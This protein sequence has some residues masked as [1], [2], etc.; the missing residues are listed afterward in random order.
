MGFIIFIINNSDSLIHF[1]VLY[2]LM[3]R[4][5]CVQCHFD[6]S[7]NNV[8]PRKLVWRTEVKIPCPC[9]KSEHRQQSSVCESLAEIVLSIVTALCNLGNSFYKIIIDK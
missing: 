3:T 5:K 1:L 6:I 8:I 4:C 9:R 2:N 7:G